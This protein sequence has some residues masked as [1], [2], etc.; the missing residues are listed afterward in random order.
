MGDRPEN[1]NSASTSTSRPR[2]TNIL[3]MP[4]QPLLS[5][6]VQAM[7][8]WLVLVR[9]ARCQAGAQYTDQIE[10]SQALRRWIGL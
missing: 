8:Q 6:P 3:Q 2:T 7:K 10:N 9:R 1:T 5:G 4:A